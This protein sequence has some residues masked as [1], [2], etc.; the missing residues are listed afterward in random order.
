MSS[1]IW[2]ATV[3]THRY[4]GV[5]VGLL[6][7]VWFFS[8]IVMMYVNF[9]SLRSGRTHPF[10]LAHRLA[11]PVAR[12]MAQPFADDQPDPLG[13]DSERHRRTRDEAAARRSAAAR[14]EPRR[15]R[16]FARARHGASARG[17]GRS[18]ASHHRRGRRPG[19][20]RGSRPRSVDGQRAL[21]PAPSA[22][23]FRLRRSRT[24]A[25]L[26]V[27]RHGRGRAVDHAERALL[28]LARL[29]SALDL[30]DRAPPPWS[31]LGAGR[32]LEL[33][34]RR[35][36][37]RHRALYRHRAAQAPGQRTALAL[38]RLVLLAPHLAV[39]S[40]AC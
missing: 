8:G 29:H 19:R 18:G 26:R 27:Q 24:H 31:A 40:S 1:L 5:A 22:L 6:M 34:R 30:S 35:F 37:D 11:A 25:D 32:H 36:P 15:I 23:P 20:R 39:S 38:S 2:R 3:I 7:F 10:A 17:R 33:D 21:Q 28:E 16:S 4:L 13:R 9:P 14:R 12:S